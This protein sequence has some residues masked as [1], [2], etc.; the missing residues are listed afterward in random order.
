MCTPRLRP[1]QLPTRGGSHVVLGRDAG[2]AM[3]L[4][5]AGAGR[6]EVGDSSGSAFKQKE[7]QREQEERS[8]PGE[9][10]DRLWEEEAV[11][12]Y[13]IHKIYTEHIYNA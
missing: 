12:S 13:T 11:K 10:T 9:A 2:A 6:E 7:M 3:L 1:V 8:T 4:R 5:V